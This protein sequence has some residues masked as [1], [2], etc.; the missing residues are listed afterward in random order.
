M[1]I[2]VTGGCGFIGSNYILK[3][4]LNNSH[5][6]LNLDKL[7]YA[8]NTEN[9]SN[10]INKSNY[11]FVNGDICDGEGVVSIIHEFQPEA[12]VH[13]AAES[14][15]DRSIKE[16]MDFVNTNVNGTATLLQAALQYWEKQKKEFR[17]LSYWSNG[18]NV[19]LSSNLKA[20][21]SGI[22]IN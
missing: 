14:H 19:P 22:H 12:I 18:C 8:G 13:F 6:V 21:I 2:L 20:L 9:L 17:Y 11:S 5:T 1:K 7:T 4:V 10:I 3:Q 15:V 16:P